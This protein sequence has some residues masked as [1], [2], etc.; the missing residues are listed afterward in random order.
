LAAAVVLF[1][2]AWQRDWFNI[3][4][5]FRAAWETITQVFDSVFTTLAPAWTAFTDLLQGN[6]VSAWM[7]M[8]QVVVDVVGFIAKLMTNPV[9]AIQDLIAKFGTNFAEQMAQKGLRGEQTPAGAGINLSVLG[10]GGTG[11]ARPATACEMPRS[12]RSRQEEGTDQPAERQPERRSGECPSAPPPALPRLQRR[13]YRHHPAV[14]QDPRF[15]HYRP[16]RHDPRY[17]RP[18]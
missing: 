1:A 6:W 17:Y 13:Q 14:R 7:N 10:A 16:D 18:R 11:A 15:P 2:T 5:Q 12:T 3:Q 4:E 8:K 9:G